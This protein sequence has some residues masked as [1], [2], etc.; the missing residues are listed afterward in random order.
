MN[1]CLQ[2][3]DNNCH[4]DATCHNNEGSYTCECNSGFTGDGIEC[5][6]KSWIASKNYTILKMKNNQLT[7]KLTYKQTNKQT[8]NKLTNQLTN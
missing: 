4:A 5:N 8:N 3:T 7:N 6:G 1:E 2:E